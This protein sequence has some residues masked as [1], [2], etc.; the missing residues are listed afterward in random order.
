MLTEGGGGGG[1][2]GHDWSLISTR[3]SCSSPDGPIVAASSQPSAL[4]SPAARPPYGL[5]VKC[6]A[7]EN[8]PSPPPYSTLRLLTKE[9]FAVATSI[10]ASPLK[11]P[12]STEPG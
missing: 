4:K 3:T 7:G 2:G 5:T 12:S 1:G 8:A 6:T 9:P 10:L 11:S